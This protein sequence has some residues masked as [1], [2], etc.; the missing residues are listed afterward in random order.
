[1]TVLVLIPEPGTGIDPGS[2]V[3]AGTP[4]T[5]GPPTGYLTVWYEGNR[6]GAVNLE[7]WADRV[8]NAADRMLTRY[9]T[10]AM[11]NLPAEQLRAIGTYDP[12]TGEFTPGI[13]HWRAALEA[14]LGRP[15]TDDDL[16]PSHAARRHAGMP[17]N[18]RTEEPQ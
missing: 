5:P 12:D 2:G 11:R 9:P 4:G 10:I 1:M 7:R 18:P 17:G 13:P 16:T 15:V 14:W 8:H 3:V 6:H